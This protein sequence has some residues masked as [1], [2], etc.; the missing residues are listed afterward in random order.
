[1]CIGAFSIIGSCTIGDNSIIQE[2]VIIRDCV[3]IGN[4]VLIK[5]GSIIVN[6]GFGFVKNE[7]GEWGKFP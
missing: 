1:M 3:R 7:K 2:N 4:N 5:S 6:H